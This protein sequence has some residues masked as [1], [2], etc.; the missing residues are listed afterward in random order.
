MRRAPLFALA[1]G[2]ALAAASTA[3]A[4]PPSLAAAAGTPGSESISLKN[5]IGFAVVWSRGAVLGRVRRGAI[6]VIDIAGGGDP[7]GFVRGCERRSGGLATRLVCRGRDLS[8]YI[9]GGTWKVRIR[10][11]GINAS[12][13]VRGTLG[14]DRADD[15]TGRYSIG[16]GSYR[17]WPAALRFLKIGG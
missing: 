15:G 1:A 4:T 11:R 9:H 6:T 14:L 2:L 3:S 16:G 17:R 13:V 5:G 10:G 7:G 8:F 12:G